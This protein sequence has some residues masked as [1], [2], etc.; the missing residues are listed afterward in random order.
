[1]LSAQYVCDELI[2]ADHQV[3]CLDRTPPDMEA[4]FHQVD[5]T[6]LQDTRKAW[7]LL[8]WEPRFDWRQLEEWEF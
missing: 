5:L 7:R 1:M 6:R 2:Q 4:E 3:C 8:G